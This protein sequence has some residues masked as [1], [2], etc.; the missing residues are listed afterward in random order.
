MVMKLIKGGGMIDGGSLSIQFWEVL[1]YP[2]VMLVAL[3][4]W[5]SAR[6][7]KRVDEIE[8]RYVSEQSLRRSVEGLR[9][10]IKGIHIRLDNFI[11]KR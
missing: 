10:D 7:I 3:I 4:T 5:I 11:D 1:K 2:A 6:T 8:K 9:R